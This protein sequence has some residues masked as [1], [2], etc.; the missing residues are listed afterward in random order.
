MPCA[1]FMDNSLT[2]T[3]DHGGCRQVRTTVCVC[4]PAQV[5]PDDVMRF[6][7]D[8]NLSGN[9]MVRALGQTGAKDVAGVTDF[10]F[11]K[12]AA[13]VGLAGGLVS[14][15]TWGLSRSGG[16]GSQAGANDKICSLLWKSLIFT[17]FPNNLHAIIRKC[18]NG[19]SS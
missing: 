10:T 2:T 16:G 13:M 5:G 19:C 1:L 18:C 17:G 11:V 7:V 4:D 14:V 8:F 9:S 6:A 12:K 15:T 3:L